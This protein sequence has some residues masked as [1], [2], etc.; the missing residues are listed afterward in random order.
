MRR[1]ASQLFWIQDLVVIAAATCIALLRILFRLLLATRLDMA[2]VQTG[3]CYRV[4]VLS[5]VIDLKVANLH[6]GLIL[7][8]VDACTCICVLRANIEKA[9]LAA[10]RLRDVD[11]IFITFLFLV[12][13]RDALF[14]LVDG[15]VW[16]LG[17][18]TAAASF[19]LMQVDITIISVH[20]GTV[21]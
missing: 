13:I 4:A 11:R 17:C 3:L 1:E 9:V 19:L 10:G 14:R 21:R 18:L 15:S 16:L 20:L 12:R 7:A 5:V 6:D 8:D 2:V